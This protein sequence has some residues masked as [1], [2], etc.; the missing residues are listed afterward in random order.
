MQKCKKC[1]N[2]FKYIDVLKSIWV[3]G[4]AP[5]VCVECNTKHYVNWSTRLIL[6]LSIFTPLIIINFL[7]LSSNH[8]I[9][10]SIIHYL[11]WIFAIICITP[12]FARYHNKTNSDQDDGTKALLISNLNS[13]EAE[14]IISILESY[15]IPY[16]KISRRTDLIEVF[17]ESSHIEIYVQPH[18]LQMAKELINP[19]NIDSNIT[20]DEN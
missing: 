17:T 3:K 6:S 15:E 11:I 14:V 13:I 8:I 7:N 16:F 1:F 18:M 2:K 4:Y 12:F 9:N 10:F 5:I 20:N 19:L